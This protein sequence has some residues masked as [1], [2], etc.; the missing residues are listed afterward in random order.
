MRVRDEDRCLLSKINH[1]ASRPYVLDVD[2]AQPVYLVVR[3]E[4]ETWV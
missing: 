4:E 1:N 2:I 3:R